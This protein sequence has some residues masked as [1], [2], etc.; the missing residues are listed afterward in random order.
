MAPETI[1]I[2]RKE[3]T[4][5]EVIDYIDADKKVAVTVEVLG[6]ERDVV[7]RKRDDEYVCDTGIK[8]LTYDTRQGMTDCL[9]RLQ[10]ASAG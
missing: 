7:L 5:E 3:H 4:A 9:E 6:I 2:D 8:L 1:R 10:P